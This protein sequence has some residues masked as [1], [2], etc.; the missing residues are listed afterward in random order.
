MN[1]M[2]RPL[3]ATCD[4]CGR[5]VG[6][7]PSH[8]RACARKAGQVPAT[9]P[10]TEEELGLIERAGSFAV[11]DGVLDHDRQLQR[12]VTDLDVARLL[13]AL[14]QG[15][16]II[17][18]GRTDRW[19]APT[20]SPLKGMD[21]RYER[22][23]LSKVVNEAIRL[24]LAFVATD[25]PDGIPAL[26]RTFLVPCLTHLR[27]RFNPLAPTCSRPTNSIKRYRLL[28]ASALALVDCQ[29]C[30]DIAALE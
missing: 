6:N 22:R 3:S 29:A 2:S 28:N 15:A 17:M 27:S 25:H 26:V 5:E 24:G 16:E 13:L 1:L 18:S 19:V 7:L 9:G 12:G 14:D 8:R 30:R 10:I 21:G 23:S 20:G 4:V 11:A